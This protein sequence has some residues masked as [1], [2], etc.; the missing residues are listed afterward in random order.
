MSVAAQ[1]KCRHCHE[2]H[3]A[4]RRNRGRQRYCHQPE[5]RRASKKF[6]QRQSSQWL[7]RPAPVRLRGVP[8]RVSKAQEQ[9]MTGQS[10]HRGWRVP[11][12]AVCGAPRPAAAGLMTGQS[13][14]Y[15][16]EGNLQ[17]KIL[18]IVEE[19]GA[20]KAG[21]ALK[22]LQSEQELTIASTGG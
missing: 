8:P 7:A 13:P 5:C 20:R 11:R 22:L 10:L 4:D 15:L 2:E 18:A 21:Y 17:H 6:S 12:Q 19:Q 3:A 1:D 16:A 9:P 14:Y